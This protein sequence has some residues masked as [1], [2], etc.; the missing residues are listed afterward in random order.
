MISWRYLYCFFVSCVGQVHVSPTSKLLFQI[1]LRLTVAYKRNSVY[2][3]LRKSLGY[4]VCKLSTIHR[5]FVH[6]ADTWSVICN[7][8]SI[9]RVHVICGGMLPVCMHWRYVCMKIRVDSKSHQEIAITVQQVGKIHVETCWATCTAVMQLPSNCSS[10]YGST[11]CM[12]RRSQ[13]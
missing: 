13:V 5:R 4:D 1:E 12:S 8:K 9:A 7:A 11:A 10:L 6:S 3:S 2:H